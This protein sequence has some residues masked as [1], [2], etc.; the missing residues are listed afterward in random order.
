M[1][2]RR[3]TAPRAEAKSMA[4]RSVV[5]STRALNAPYVS[6][7]WQPNRRTGR[8]HVDTCFI[9][10]VLTVGSARVRAIQ[11]VRCAENHSTCQPIGAV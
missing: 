4:P 10:D 2:P 5:G 9:L 11:R 7:P 3:H 1:G 6:D 8:C